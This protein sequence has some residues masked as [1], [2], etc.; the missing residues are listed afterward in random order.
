MI[1]F[2]MMRIIGIVVL[3]LCLNAQPLAVTIN[4]VVNDFKKTQIINGS[5][6]VAQNNRI[7]Y[8]KSEGFANVEKKIKISGQTKFLIGSVTKLFTAVAMLQLVEQH[9]I[10]LY[11]PI[12]TYLA[13]N[14][15]FWNKKFPKWANQIT[16]AQLLTH[17][18]GLPDYT[19]L[20][21]FMNFYQHIQTP[22]S[23]LQF[24]SQERLAFK[25]GA[26]FEYSGTAY[27]LLGVI[28][29]AVTHK[30]YGTL[31]QEKFFNPLRMRHTTAPHTMMLADLQAVDPTIA[32]GYFVEDNLLEPSDNV[33]NLSTAYSEACIISTSRD[34]Y[35]WFTNLFN[36]KIVSPTTL[37]R[38][39]TP[40]KKTEEKNVSMGY[41]FYIKQD[42]N[43]FYTHGGHIKGYECR[44][45]YQP[46]NQTLVI[47]LSNAWDMG[48]DR[49]AFEIF[50]SIKNM[51]S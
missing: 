1:F 23:F 31:L 24:I 12:S 36:H 44:I 6:L 32:L 5:I 19:S 30:P 37:N 34:L 4:T 25:P 47:V 18:A 26:R 29:E 11:C 9:A 27:N 10:R 46:Y 39:V 50:D 40:H 8:E 16:I 2:M 28:I 17:S 21:Q 48:V 43:P 42:P 35:T 22:S 20:P 14:H 41:G 33:V 51:P 45:I 13:Y 49:L 38:M 7:V 15:P 3:P